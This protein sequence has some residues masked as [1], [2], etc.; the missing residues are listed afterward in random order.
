MDWGRILYKKAVYRNGN[1]CGH[2]R[3]ANNSND[4]A[5]TPQPLHF[6]MLKALR[7]SRTT[8]PVLSV[9][10]L[11]CDPLALCMTSY[12][13]PIDSSPLNQNSIYTVRGEPSNPSLAFQLSTPSHHQY[14]LPS[15]PLSRHPH[16]IMSGNS[17]SF[18]QASP[19]DTFNPADNFRGQPRPEHHIHRES[20]ALPNNDSIAYGPDQSKDSLWENRRDT[21]TSPTFR[22]SSSY[23]LCTPFQTTFGLIMG[24]FVF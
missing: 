17:N 21:G 14:H 18:S 1:N 8:C 9:T 23:V 2:Y 6:T 7:R 11:P 4:G 24:H 15:N 12:R 3:N 16:I 5:T 10:R 20:E 13:S 19:K 22:H